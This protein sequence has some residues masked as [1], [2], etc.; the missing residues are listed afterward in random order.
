MRRTDFS[1]QLPPELI[2]QEPRPRG[3]SRMMV[4]DGPRIEHRRFSEF[5]ELLSPGDVL[6]IN[7]T[8]VI[9][10]R[11]FARPKGGMKNPIEFLL[12]KQLDAMTWEA[13][14]KPARRVRPEDRVEFSDGL[15]ARVLEKREDGTVVIRFEGELE[16]IERVGVPPL[17]PYIRRHAPRESDREAY[18]TVYAAERGAIAAPTAGLHFTNEIL[19]SIAARGVEIVRI[20]L[21]VGI[22]TFRPVKVDDISLH[23]MD[24]ERYEI[25]GQAAARLNRAREDKRPIVAVGTT[26]VRALES[27]IRAGRFE[28]GR[29]ETDIFITPGFEFRAVDRL[30]TN[31]H[32]PESTLLMLVSAFA[33]VETIRNA[34]REAIAQKYFFY[35]YGDCMFLRSRDSRARG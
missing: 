20:T 5:P 33:G 25:G 16:E 30:L 34:Y 4:V 7:D 1:Y 29:A 31:F 24:V 3:H 6:A 13:W 28:P 22:G 19:D 10:A 9:P 15:A 26:T 21:H 23:R 35:S 18:Q 17:P 32:L 12:V 27:A 8:R 2:A 14:C 11:L